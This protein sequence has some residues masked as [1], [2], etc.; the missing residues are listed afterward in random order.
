MI[1]AASAAAAITALG[2]FLFLNPQGK[3]INPLGQEKEDLINLTQIK[4]W[5]EW[6]DEAGFAFEY[7]K[8]AKLE[9]IMD[10]DQNYSQLRLTYSGKPGVI[11]IVCQ[12]SQYSNIDD[13]VAKDS[14]VKNYSSLDTKI[15]SFSAKR[16]ALGEGKE[17]AAFIDNDIVIYIIDKQPEGEKYWQQVYSHIIDTFKL[18]PLAGENQQ[19]FNNWLGDFGSAAEESDYIEPFEIIQ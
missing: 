2:Y 18:I 17:I 10:N 19:D 15:A 6:K 9:Q 14:K 13:W 8:E 3:I 4:D 11:T 16:V 1:A 12:N 5:Q 7:P